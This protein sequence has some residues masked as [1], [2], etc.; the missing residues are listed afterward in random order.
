MAFDYWDFYILDKIVLASSGEE[1][2]FTDMN[3]DSEMDIKVLAKYEFINIKSVNIKSVNAETQKTIN[4]YGN[5]G[6]I[7][8]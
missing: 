8:N 7:L 1:V 5:F 3:P 6:K 2:L 4:K